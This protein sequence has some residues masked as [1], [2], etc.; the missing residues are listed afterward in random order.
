MLI[1]IPNTLHFIVLKHKKKIISYSIVVYT[2]K[3]FITIQ[4]D[5]IKN[6]KTYLSINFLELN[7]NNKQLTYTSL[8]SD[9]IYTWSNFFLKK[10]T[11]KG[12]G[13]KIV[14]K[15][16]FLLL[17]F[18]HAHLTWLLLFNTICIKNT[19]QKFFLILKNY[20]KLNNFTKTILKIRPINIYTK[21]GLKEA[22]QKI[23]KKIGKRT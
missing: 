22:K 23:L 2:H 4:I 15:K 9:Y 1:Y 12:K 10:I 17:N 13:Y 19:K 16:K 21:R 6:I 18:N 11:F 14:K 7:I 8:L 20:K 3:K 5:S